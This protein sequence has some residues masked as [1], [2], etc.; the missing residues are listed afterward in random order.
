MPVRSHLSGESTP[1]GLP[2]MKTTTDLNKL[3]APQLRSWLTLYGLATSGS[4]VKDRSLL[5][6]YLISSI[7]EDLE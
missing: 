7:E 3:K 6:S 1:N 5:W 4:I 2:A